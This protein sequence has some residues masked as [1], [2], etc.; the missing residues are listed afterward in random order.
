MS[1][2]FLVRTLR[3]LSWCCGRILSTLGSRLG[4]VV[5]TLLGSRLGTL[6]YTLAEAFL[7]FFVGTCPDMLEVLR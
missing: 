5:A 4:G 6:V 3:S 2:Y 7:Q 1:V